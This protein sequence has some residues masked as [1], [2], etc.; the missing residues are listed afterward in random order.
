MLGFVD[1]VRVR[2]DA[3]QATWIEPFN[4]MFA[5]APVLEEQAM[6]IMQAEFPEG[7]GT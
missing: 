1:E 3:R 4:E 6:A 7:S 2:A 5:E